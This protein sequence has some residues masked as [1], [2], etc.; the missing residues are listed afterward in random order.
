MNAGNHWSEVTD[1]M[2]FVDEIA[3]KSISNYR[4]VTQYRVSLQWAENHFLDF[5]SDFQYVK[6]CLFNF[7]NLIT[8]SRGITL[9]RFKVDSGGKG[10][11]DVICIQTWMIVCPGEFNSFDNTKDTLLAPFG[12]SFRGNNILKQA[13]WICVD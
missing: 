4:F 2:A 3:S 7:A 11:S 9:T 8:I 10:S 1:T 5:L 6:C 13:R 12:C